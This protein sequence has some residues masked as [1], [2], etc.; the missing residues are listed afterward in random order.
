MILLIQSVER[1]VMKRKILLIITMLPF[2]SWLKENMRLISHQ[3][4]P[5]VELLVFQRDLIRVSHM[6]MEIIQLTINL[7]TGEREHHQLLSKLD[8]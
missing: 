8:N 5:T 3:M 1:I 6:M 2:Q 4:I 7:Q